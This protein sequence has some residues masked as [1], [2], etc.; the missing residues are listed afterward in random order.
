M[1]VSSR[2]SPR[3]P[4]ANAACVFAKTLCALLVPLATLAQT[5]DKH[6]LNLCGAGAC[7]L[8]R[9][10][11]SAT[12]SPTVPTTIPKILPK[13]A[14]SRADFFVPFIFSPLGADCDAAAANGFIHRAELDCPMTRPF[15]GELMCAG[16]TFTCAITAEARVKVRPWAFSKSRHTDTVCRLSE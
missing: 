4:R 8:R 11:F 16:A 5:V 6:E 9:P 7:P 1:G 12:M 2:R 13:I 3:V 14:F 15:V 10:F